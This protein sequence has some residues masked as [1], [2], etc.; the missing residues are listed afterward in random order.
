MRDRSNEDARA[1]WEGKE[2]LLLIAVTT[3]FHSLLA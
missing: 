3:T 2:A 1:I